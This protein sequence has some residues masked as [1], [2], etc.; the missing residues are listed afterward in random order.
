MDTTLPPRTHRPVTRPAYP[1]ALVRRCFGVVARPQTH[2]NIAFLL[3]GLP[4]GTVWFSLLV[5][6]VSVGIS[7]LAVALLGIPILLGVWYSTRAFANVERA[8]ANRLLDLRLAP[9]PMAS[10]GHG[11]LWTRLRAMTVDRRRWTELGYLLARFPIGIATFTATAVA[12]ATPALVAY[13]PFAARHEQEPFGDW[14]LSSTME[15]VAS[16]PLWSWFLVPLGAAMLVG[17][18]HLLNKLAEACGR[19]AAAGLAGDR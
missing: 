16:T 4:L 7:M 11:N 1:S 14:A 15:D 2:R 19:F 5:T 3:L 9:A 6:G 17:S 8:T 18:L 13:A 12:L 10:G